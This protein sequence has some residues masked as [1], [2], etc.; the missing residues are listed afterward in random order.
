MNYFKS[1]LSKS[2]KQW[3]TFLIAS[4]FFLS[5]IFALPLFSIP[6]ILAMLIYSNVLAWFLAGTVRKFI[7]NLFSFISLLV[8]SSIASTMLEPNYV[9][10]TGVFLPSVFFLYFGILAMVEMIKKDYTH[11]A[12]LS[13]T[14]PAIDVSIIFLLFAYT[15]KL[16]I[17][18]SLFIAILLLFITSLVFYLLFK[19]NDKPNDLNTH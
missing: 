11:K 4:F 2:T 8:I 7:F 15:S 5:V 1:L 14:I 16:S 10:L 12:L 17:Y 19:S 9:G 18:L 3:V 6:S 13:F